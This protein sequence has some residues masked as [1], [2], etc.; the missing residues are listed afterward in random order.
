MSLNDDTRSYLK[1]IPAIETTYRGYRFR[2]RLEARWAVFFDAA[3][4]VWQYEPEAFSLNG[5]AY[6]PDFWLPQFETF[7]EVKPTKEAAESAIPVLR[8]LVTKTGKN[9]LLITGSPNINNEPYSLTGI[10]MRSSDASSPPWSGKVWWKPCICCG[11]IAIGGFVS[12]C[13]CNIAVSVLRARYLSAGFRLIIHA[14]AEAQRARFEHGENGRPRPYSTDGLPQ[15]DVYVAGSVIENVVETEHEGEE[16]SRPVVVP[17]RYEVFDAEASYQFDAGRLNDGRFRYAG[18]TIID[19]HGQAE[20]SLAKDCIRE[21]KESD[22]LFAWI[23]R[24]DTIGTLAEIGAAHALGKPIFIAFA[25]RELS[26]H[27]YFAY[28]LSIVS[29]VAPDVTTAWRCFKNWQNH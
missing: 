12:D 6:M 9:T 2:S 16:Y 4:I 23:D 5:R 15:V 24:F 27:F 17:W 22:A 26:D 1:S 19:H 13:Q 11:N 29:I 25:S 8:S 7:V 21:V 14:M 18:P 20:L 10:E 3:G 28:Q